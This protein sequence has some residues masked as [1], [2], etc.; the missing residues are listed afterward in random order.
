MEEAF[1]ETSTARSLPHT[2]STSLSAAQADGEQAK[3]Y[4]AQNMAHSYVQA[5]ETVNLE[6]NKGHSFMP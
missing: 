4:C 6:E 3:R 2:Y 1:L 5:S